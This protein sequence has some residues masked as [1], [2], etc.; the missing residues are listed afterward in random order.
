MSFRLRLILAFT[1]L[2]LLQ[3]AFFTLL[4]DQLIRDGIEGEADARLALVGSLFERELPEGLWPLPA[5]RSPAWKS[6]MLGEL[7][8]FAEA[9]GLDRATLLLGPAESYD[10]LKGAGL[11]PNSD[12]W[13][14]DALREPKLKGRGHV[15]GPLFHADDGWHK[16]LYFKMK[17]DSAWLRIEAGTPFLGQVAAIQKRLFRLALALVLPSL[18]IGLALAYALS[19]RAT[20]LKKKLE[21]PRDATLSLGGRDEFSGIAASMDGLL[22]S[23]KAEREHSEKLLQGRISQARHLAFGVAH[24]L[25]NPLSGL[26]L[27]VELLG[28]KSAEGAQPSELAP[29]SSRIQAEAARLEHTV[30]RFLDFARTPVLS[31][32]R[33]DLRKAVDDALNGLK[34][35]PQ[36]SGAGEA[37]ADFKSCAVIAGILLSNACESAG[38]EGSVKA[39]IKDGYLSVWDS[40]APVPAESRVRLFTP[41]F[42]TK[43]RGMGLGLATASGLADAMGGR[44]SLAED[45][46]TFELRLPLP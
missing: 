6:G 45:G 10:S 32:A 31:T 44:L 34:P 24:E 22:Q 18:L 28:R 7:T 12:R 8:D 46:K 37:M 33:L 11:G 16:T 3:A 4:S 21:G 5:K 36:V 42:T 29:I 20:Q 39:E 40:G 41:F 13:L 26:S 1:A 15:S 27:M 43:P 9:Y 23:L 14:S 35:A 19:R 38:D 25:R 30:A 17:Q 2:A